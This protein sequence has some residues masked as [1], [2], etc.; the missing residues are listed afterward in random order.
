MFSELGMLVTSAGGWK[1]PFYSSRYGEYKLAAK[2][3]L[4]G[5]TGNVF[6]LS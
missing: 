5:P 4:W 6:L 3:K 1:K 2:M